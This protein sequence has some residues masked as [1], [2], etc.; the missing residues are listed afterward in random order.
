MEKLNGDR[1]AELAK[2]SEYVKTIEGAN[3]LV[4]LVYL[5]GK[6][7][8]QVELPFDKLL[9]EVVNAELRFLVDSVM[10]RKGQ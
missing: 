9:E 2:D 10:E 6:Y 7:G 4:L 3:Q 8:F 1:I 5:E